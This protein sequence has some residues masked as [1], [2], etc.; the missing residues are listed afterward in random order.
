M[1]TRRACGRVA[2]ASASPAASPGSIQQSGAVWAGVQ[3]AGR[4]CSRDWAATAPMLQPLRALRRAGCDAGV[5]EGEISKSRQRWLA[6]G[7]ES[8]PC[9][10]RRA[11][12]RASRRRRHVQMVR[13]VTACSTH[14]CAAAAACCRRRCRLLPPPA[15]SASPSGA[16]FVQGLQAFPIPIVSTPPIYERVHRERSWRH[17][18]PCKH[19]S[20]PGRLCA[21]R[22]TEWRV[23]SDSTELPYNTRASTISATAPGRP[24]RLRHRA[25]VRK[26]A[27]SSADRRRHHLRSLAV[28]AGQRRR[29]RFL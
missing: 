27:R 9:V 15:E 13:S 19:H 5:G 12:L 14:A 26:S 2:S 17:L 16:A 18:C 7:S 24:Q 1:S 11:A 6:C 20:S 10:C 8:A 4:Q 3:G 29:Q 25:A 23:K 22:Y 21:Q 28:G